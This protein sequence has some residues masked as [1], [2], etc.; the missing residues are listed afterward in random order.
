MATLYFLHLPI[1]QHGDEN[2]NHQHIRKEN[3]LRL[4]LTQ[5]M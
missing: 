4:E 3:D 5:T 2:A 1:S